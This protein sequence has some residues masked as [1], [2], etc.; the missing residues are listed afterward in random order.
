MDYKKRIPQN[1]QAER[2]TLKKV[3]FFI[4][5][6]IIYCKGRKHL[7]VSVKK[8]VKYISALCKLTSQRRLSVTLDLINLAKT[9]ISQIF[10][11]FLEKLQ[12]LLG[13]LL[14]PLPLEFSNFWKD[15]NFSNFSLLRANLNISCVKAGGF[16]DQ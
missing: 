5:S 10:L 3:F 15:C 2:L 12:F 1:V 11:Q 16:P 7:N 9:A 14:P 4:A 8:K 13:A 6:D